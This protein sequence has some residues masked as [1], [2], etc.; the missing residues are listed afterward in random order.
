MRMSQTAPPAQVPRT[1]A[2]TSLC[3]LANLVLATLGTEKF[4]Q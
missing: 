4:Y 3:T 1:T 2:G